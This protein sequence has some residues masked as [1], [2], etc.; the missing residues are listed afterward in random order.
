M[1]DDTVSRTISV[2][3]SGAS[4]T[5]TS[6]NK[7]VATVTLSGNKTIIT[8]K[9]SGKATITVKATKSGHTS[10]T[11]TFT[12]VVK[13]PMDVKEFRVEPSF[14]PGKK[15]VIVYLYADNPGGYKVAVGGVQLA[16]MPEKGCFYGDVPEADALISKVKVSK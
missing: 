15:T 14:L 10:A 2:Q 3:P 1:V 6:S 4:I 16:F 12:V 8:G 5:V 7:S 13:G 9:G 11:R